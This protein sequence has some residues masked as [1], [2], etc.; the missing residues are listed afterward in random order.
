MR[1]IFERKIE[2]VVSL[3]PRRT[4]GGEGYT[5][6]V[7][8][9]RDRAPARP[10]PRRPPGPLAISFSR[11]VELSQVQGGLPQTNTAQ[12]CADGGLAGETRREPTRT[13][14]A[15]AGPARDHTAHYLPSSQ[16]EQQ[17]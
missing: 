14:E 8:A 7:L 11:K 2:V 9:P 13:A 17:A 6:L 3:E 12:Q 5:S 4:R 10:A 1:V 16:A 15:G